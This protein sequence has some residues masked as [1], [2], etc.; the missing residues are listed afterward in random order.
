M[1]SFNRMEVFPVVDRFQ[2][3]ETLPQTPH[4]V[5]EYSE[6]EAQMEQVAVVQV[7]QLLL[8]LWDLQTVLLL[9]LMV[10]MEEISKLSLYTTLNKHK[11][12]VRVVVA[13]VVI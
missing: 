1:F 11:L 5:L 3:M 6:A 9:L 7:V 2:A 13:V 8:K 4:Q 10:V 12:K